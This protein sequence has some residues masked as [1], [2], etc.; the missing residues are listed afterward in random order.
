MRLREEDGGIVT[1]WLVQMIAILAVIGLI[2]YEVVSI[3]VSNVSAD[4]SAREVARAARDAY[5]VEQS[6]DVAQERAEEIAMTRDVSVTLVDEEDG[7][8]VVEVERQAPTLLVHRIG[9]LEDL[10]TTSAQS[11]VRLAP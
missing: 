6:I 5:R 11:R 2:V 9:P 10:A 3:M 4:D 7:F 1:G 8:L